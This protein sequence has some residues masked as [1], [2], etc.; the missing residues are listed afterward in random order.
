MLLGALLAGG[1]AR[2]ALVAVQPFEAE[3]AGGALVRAAALVEADAVARS[4]W[5]AARDVAGE[6]VCLSR[7]RACAAPGSS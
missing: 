3:G 5:V 7:A 6:A 4:V 2:L 1:V